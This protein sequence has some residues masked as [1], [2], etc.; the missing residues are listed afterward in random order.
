MLIIICPLQHKSIVISCGNISTV[1]LISNGP[2]G[3]EVVITPLIVVISSVVM[4]L[5]VSGSGSGCMVVCTPVGVTVGQLEKT[6]ES[7]LVLCCVITY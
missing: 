5:V 4:L 3:S 2:Y 7:K 6:C 1:P